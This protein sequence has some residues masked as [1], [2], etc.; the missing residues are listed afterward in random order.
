MTNRNIYLAKKD[1]KEAKKIWREFYRQ[2]TPKKTTI[3]VPQARGR[4]A[5]SPVRARRSAPQYNAAAMDGIAVKA[6]SIKGVNERNPKILEKNTDFVEVNTGEPLPP[7][8]NAV[9]K[10]EEVELLS[11]DKAKIYSAVSPWQDVRTIGESVL[12]GEQLLTTGQ[13]IQEY[14]LGALIEAGIGK[15]EVYKKP[16]LGLVATGDEIVSAEKEPDVGEIVDFNSTMIKSWSESN[17]IEVNFAG[18]IPDDYNKI[19]EAVEELASKVDLLLVIAGS[20]AGKKDFTP[21]IIAD[22][23]EVLL[24][25][26]AISPGKPVLLGQLQDKP[27]IGLPGY[28]LSC[29]LDFHLFAVPL[30]N[31]LTGQKEEREY[32]KVTAKVLRKVTSH[33]GRLEFLRA[34]LF[35]PLTDQGEEKEPQ[36]IAVPRSRGAAAMK[37]LLKADG[38]LMI[39][40]EREGLSPGSEAEV[41]LFKGE[42]KSQLKNNLL[43][44]GSNDP[45]LEIIQE[46]LSQD[47]SSYCLKLQARGSQAGLQAL[48]RGECQLTAAHLLNP[49]KSEYNIPYLE[50]IGQERYALFTLAWREQG[51]LVPRGNPAEVK[52]LKDL[53]EKNISFINRQR[54]AGTRILFD[55]LLNN[56]ELAAEDIT[57]YDREEYTHAAVAQAV[58]AGT[59]EASLGI[60]AMAEAFD[61]DFIP[62]ATERFELIFPARLEEHPAIKKLLEI[63]TGPEIEQEIIKQEGYKLPTDLDDRIRYCKPGGINHGD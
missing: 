26:V 6:D 42:S 9:I 14:D 41:V 40:A 36:P 62:I 3:P 1:L 16:Q 46:Q 45:L 39:P 11:A 18:I 4:I 13:K 27:V 43:L 35:L 23:G 54:G 28:P 33:P 61:L 38:L 50:K 24:H 5:A 63:V 53:T 55:Y 32:P 37:S 44:L 49:E 59:A 30:L 60:K 20:S 48:V 22:K 12:K 21:Q 57:G 52:E 25:G 29:L 47:Y 7:G 31:W 56:N 19:S 10:I 8:Y 58:A 15:V 34:N 17:N 2:I 51:L